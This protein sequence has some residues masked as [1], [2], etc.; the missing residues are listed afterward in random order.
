MQQDGYIGMSRRDDP[1]Q[2]VAEAVMLGDDV[3]GLAL[4]GGRRLFQVHQRSCRRRLRRGRWRSWRAGMTA[5]A[6]VQVA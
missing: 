3:E 4:D 6:G 5:G 2:I 1:G